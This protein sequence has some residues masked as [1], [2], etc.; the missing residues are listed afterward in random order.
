M[1]HQSEIAF[2]KDLTELEEAGKRMSSTSSPCEYF[3]FTI[4]GE[5]YQ[6][7]KNAGADGFVD[8]F[9]KVISERSQVNE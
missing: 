4:E 6:R 7:I 2:Y 1:I 3:Y 5:D 8:E 9:L